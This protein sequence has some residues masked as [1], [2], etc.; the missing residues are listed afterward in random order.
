MCG[1][2]SNFVNNS[3]SAVS[4]EATPDKKALKLVRLQERGI[5]V[6]TT[7]KRLVSEA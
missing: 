6:L 4:N 3:I 2:V 7:T 5:N 1:E